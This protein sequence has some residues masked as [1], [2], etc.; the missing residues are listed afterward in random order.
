[1]TLSLRQ[2]AHAAAACRRSL[3]GDYGFDPLSLGADAEALKW[4]QQAELIHGRWA[5]L[6]GALL[7]GSVLCAL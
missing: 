4:N 1:L 5:M 6:G 3:P 2:S 7:Y